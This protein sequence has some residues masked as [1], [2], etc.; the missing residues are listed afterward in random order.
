M[1]E[2]DRDATARED[3]PSARRVAGGYHER[4]REG[5]GAERKGSR[6]S[7]PLRADQSG[8]LSNQVIDGGCD[9]GRGGVKANLRWRLT[10]SSADG[11]V[12]HREGGIADPGA[13]GLP[14]WRSGRNGRRAPPKSDAAIA[15]SLQI[16]SCLRRRR[17]SGARL[18]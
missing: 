5:K 3:A 12:G 1:R 14:G 15:T 10:P 17:T 7:L 9:G 16:S 11:I 2:D 6:R 18:R 4:P 8:R 13:C